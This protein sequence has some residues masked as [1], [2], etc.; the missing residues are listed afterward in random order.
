MGWSYWHKPKH[1]KAVEELLGNLV[2]EN[3]N[4]KNEVL[5]HAFV[6][7]SEFYAV[8]KRTKPDGSVRHFLAVSLVKF[9]R[10]EYNMGCKD[11]SEEMGPCANR[12]PERLL[13]LMDKLVPLPDP[14][15]DATGYAKGFRDRCRAFHAR[16][17]AAPKP[18]TRIRFTN[19]ITFVGGAKGAE[20]TLVGNGKRSVFQDDAG[21]RYR[22]R[23]W[24]DRGYT[25][26]NA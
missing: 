4:G 15:Y 6:A 25:I 3:E 24:T 1:R 17:K 14:S 21:N 10:G 20:F 9:C 18:G 2:W 16:R 8:C 22:I 12:C 7:R 13:D 26:V 23:N 19:E 11:M 5:A